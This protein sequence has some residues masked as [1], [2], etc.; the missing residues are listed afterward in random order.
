MLCII[1]TLK[2][3]LN[4]RLAQGKYDILNRKVY[5]FYLWIFL[6]TAASVSVIFFSNFNMENVLY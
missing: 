5:R 6:T 2:K 1:V 4:Y 3:K